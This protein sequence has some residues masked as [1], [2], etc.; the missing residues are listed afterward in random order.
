[1]WNLLIFLA[2]FPVHS[3]FHPSLSSRHVSRSFC[4]SFKIRTSFFCLHF[5]IIIFFRFRGFVFWHRLPLPV[6]LPSES[7]TNIRNGMDA[8]SQPSDRTGGQN[9]DTWKLAS[10]AVNILRAFP[11]PYTGGVRVGIKRNSFM[12]ASFCCRYHNSVSRRS[13]DSNLNFLRNYN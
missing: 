8:A 12:R 3:T 9:L 10:V 5:F 4:W 6:P 1:M 7:Y 11:R 2:S 13:D